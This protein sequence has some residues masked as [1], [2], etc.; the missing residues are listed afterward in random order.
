MQ[1][2][3]MACPVRLPRPSSGEKRELRRGWLASVLQTASS[4]LL[5][6]N[7]LAPPLQ[8][9]RLAEQRKTSARSLSQP[10]IEFLGRGGACR[11]QQVC[12]CSKRAARV[13]SDAYETKEKGR[14]E[15]GQR[16]NYKRDD[17]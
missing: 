1:F 3:R 17:K 13:A 6:Q 14:Q 5:G 2:A 9:L 8:H 11:L 12:E 10:L 4:L 16:Q 15:Q 7:A